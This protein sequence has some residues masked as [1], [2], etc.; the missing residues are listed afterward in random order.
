[1]KFGMYFSPFYVKSEVALH[2]IFPQNN[3]G[4]PASQGE[5]NYISVLYHSDSP[6]NTSGQKGMQI[7]TNDAGKISIPLRIDKTM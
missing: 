1:M 5:L 4:L 3:Y 6:F 7:F 2:E